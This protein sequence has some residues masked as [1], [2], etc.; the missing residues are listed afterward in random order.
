[1]HGQKNIKIL[2][3]VIQMLKHFTNYRFEGECSTLCSYRAGKN[4]HF[5]YKRQA[6]N[7]AYSRSL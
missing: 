3:V 6:V 2:Y 5:S 7:L 1:M 4:L